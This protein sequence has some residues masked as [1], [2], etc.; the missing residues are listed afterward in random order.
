MRVESRVQDAAEATAAASL[1]SGLS[2]SIGEA[3]KPS[4]ADSD[5]ADRCLSR[6]SDNRLYLAISRLT[7]V[8]S[9]LR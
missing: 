5:L 6:T 9:T 3:L 2:S 7:S 8:S 1:N 4:P